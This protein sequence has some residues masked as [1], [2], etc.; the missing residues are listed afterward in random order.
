[1]HRW[2]DRGAAIIPK[3]DKIILMRRERG[4]GKN[5]QVYYTI[6]GGG[7]EENEKIKDTAIREIKEELGIKIDA[8]KLLYKLNTQ[9]RMQYIFLGKYISGQLG[10]GEGEEFQREDYDKYGKYIPQ[11]VGYEQ[12]KRIKLVPETLKREIIKDYFYIIGK[13]KRNH[14]LK[15]LSELH[16]KSV[17]NRKNVNKESKIQEFRK[18]ISKNFKNKRER[19]YTVKNSNVDYSIHNENIKKDK[20]YKEKSYG[21]EKDQNIKP[22]LGKRNIQE[23]ENSSWDKGKEKTFKKGR[24]FKKEDF[25]IENMSPRKGFR[26]K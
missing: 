22:Y 19:I 11:V 7:R 26:K 5:K 10:T 18:Q 6:P 8:P 14:T 16:K 20:T 21:V 23:R 4:Y 9:M 15:I 17:Q 24:K 2:T 12:L 13:S 25:K 1:M 3:G